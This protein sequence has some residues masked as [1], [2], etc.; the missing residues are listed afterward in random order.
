[1]TAQSST[2]STARRLTRRLHFHDDTRHERALPYTPFDW[3]T[4]ASGK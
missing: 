3:P 4:Q 1:L 2:G